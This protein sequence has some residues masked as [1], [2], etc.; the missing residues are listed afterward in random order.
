MTTAVTNQP[1][2][3]TTYFDRL[4]KAFEDS[5]QL[6][7]PLATDLSA[8]ISKPLE[9]LTPDVQGFILNNKLDDLRPCLTQGLDMFEAISK[10][11][12]A[13]TL[14]LA[15]FQNTLATIPEKIVLPVEVS[16]H[17]AQLDVMDAYTSAEKNCAT[18]REKL[19]ATTIK[20]S[21]LVKDTHT[22]IESMRKPLNTMAYEV[23]RMENRTG[24]SDRL[25]SR[26]YYYLEEALTAF[27]T[28]V[29][30]AERTTT[31]VQEATEKEL[32]ELKTS[33][34]SSTEQQKV[35]TPKNAVAELAASLS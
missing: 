27:R 5:T 7:Q 17:L 22:F 6:V 23:K 12:A 10:G 20:L 4:N 9:L 2:N 11:H 25:P 28:P 31:A 34:S 18:G 21:G 1:V 35:A 16:N 30:A 19:N 29:K 24:L 26:G 3:P 32:A 15:Q 13:A 14:A 8:R 33:S